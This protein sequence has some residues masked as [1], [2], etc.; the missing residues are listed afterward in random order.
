M[1]KIV[2]ALSLRRVNQIIS[3]TAIM[4]V[5][6]IGSYFVFSSQAAGVFNSTEPE[7]GTI[8]QPATKVA[9]V[10]ASG[11]NYVKFGSAVTPPTYTC[12]KTL[13]AG[14]NVKSF[15]DSLASGETGCLRAGTYST[16][17]I[18]FSSSGAT[19]A[20]YPGERATINLGSSPN[21]ATIAR[22]T[23]GMTIKRINFTTTSAHVLRVY[24]NNTILE[25]NQ[26]TDNHADGAGSCVGIGGTQD[27]PDGVIIRGNKFVNCGGVATNLNH[28]IYALS[29]TNLT[30]VDNVFYG[31][32]AYV[33]QLYPYAEHAIIRH[34]VI[35]GSNEYS[36]RG[37]IVIDADSSSSPAS[38]IIENNIINNTA[39]TA[40]QARVGSGHQVNSNC[41]YQNS[42][43]DISGSVAQ[44]GNVNTNPMYVNRTTHDYHL[45]PGSPCLA[46]VQYDTAAKIDQTW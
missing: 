5:I 34:N 37:S 40:I 11:G 39:V 28:S 2:S 33:I 4:S 23:T 24:G 1:N 42:G 21:Q 25:N 3:L 44:T 43:G 17:S 41:F 27:K 9:D 10:T 26:F 22:G 16:G 31:T 20:S 46:V 29:F 6:A 30:I 12:T 36:I 7:D 45:S 15:S 35:D 38:A 18:D 14:G 13:A 8:T 19:L 32:G